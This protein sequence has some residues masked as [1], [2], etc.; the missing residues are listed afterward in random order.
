VGENPCGVDVQVLGSLRVDV[1]GRPASLGGPRLRALL[2]S[3]IAAAG[4]PV[5]VSSLVDLLWGAHAPDD[6]DRTVRTYM[7]RLR[8]ALLPA[9][10]LIV[11]RQPGY[12]LRLDPDGV[13]AARFERLATAGRQSLEAGRPDVAVGQLTAALGLWHGEAYE[14]F[15]GIAVLDAEARRLTE[16]R[17]NAVQDRVDA[18]LATGHGQDLIAELTALTTD[19]P[20]NER[21]WGQLMTA[22]YRAGRQ[23][24]ALDAYRHARLTLIER[25]GVEP[26][27]ALTAIHRQILAQDTGLLTPP[28]ITGDPADP[29]GSA[30][31]AGADALHDEGDLLASRQQFE[32]AYGL[33]TRAGD[34]TGMARAVLGL[35][36]LWVHEHRT[37]TS[38]NQL[39]SRLA[40]ALTAVDSGSPEALRLRVRLAGEGD[41]QAA[42]HAGILALLDDTRLAEDPAVHT[43]ALSIAHH[44]VLGPDHAALR[45]AL[46]LELIGESQRT[47]RRVDRLMGL[48]WHTIDLFL[49]GDPHAERRLE[50]LELE[51]ADRAHL[52]V[53]FAV[54]AM[55]VMLTIRA[56][57]F[58]E[59]EEQAKACAELGQAAGDADAVG[60]YGAQLMAIRWFQGRLTELLP[61]LDELVHS[62]TLSTID[63]SYFA[64]LA[65]AA[66]VAG[67]QRKAAGSLARL[68]GHDL[69][70]LP[71][72]SSWLVSMSG[73]AETAYLLDDAATAARVHGLLAPYAN[74]PMMASL[75][76]ACFGSTRQALGVAA[77]AMGDVNRAVD[78]LHAAVQHNLA[79]GHWP[80]VVVSR[81]RHA[82]A[83]ASRAGPGDAAAAA[84]EL[85]VAAKDAAELGMPVPSP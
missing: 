10:D 3:L 83:L 62:S 63:N 32:I 55:R 60:W 54:S 24:D 18:E 46:A 12:L 74:L 80:A 65:V 27:A 57:H 36:G 9:A 70:M 7:S 78:H 39:H 47:R 41:Y 85:A 40:Q 13:D 23:S 17:Y 77:M 5:A 22:L 67:D 64:A 11:T 68:V 84:R 76:V 42:G 66:A 15:G 35:G 73:I 38:K 20:A 72:S 61:L 71:R 59:A 56:G 28:V 33:A 34:G 31:A 79:L 52:A 6:A 25:S 45:R 26:S 53:G 4:R 82:R 44:C 51:L 1:D 19:H 49:A 37:A 16:L 8:K 29:L 30:L 75:A 14:E 21:L 43:E 81:T 48:L 58:D 69:A 50:E 2:A